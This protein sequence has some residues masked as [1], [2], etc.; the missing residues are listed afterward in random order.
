MSRQK[1]ENKIMCLVFQ[2]AGADRIIL[3]LHFENANLYLLNCSA[4][5]LL[6]KSCFIV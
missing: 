3:S 2:P 1:Y 6:F 4:I 5:Q